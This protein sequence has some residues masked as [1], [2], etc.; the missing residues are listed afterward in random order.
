MRRDDISGPAI[1]W[2][3]KDRQTNA[4]CAPTKAAPG[5]GK[6]HLISG[7]LITVSGGAVAAAVQATI[8]GP[9]GAASNTFTFE[10]P[11]ATVPPTGIPFT[12]PAPVVC[13]ENTAAS[14]SIPALGAS[15]VANAQLF[16][17]TTTV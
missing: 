16:G 17:S 11:A 1:T 14:L 8:S 13:A 5:A 3:A 2:V 6:R 15:I 12:F 10:I 7:F 9:D 4:T